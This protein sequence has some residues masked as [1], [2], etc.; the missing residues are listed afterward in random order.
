MIVA[1]RY[2]CR[3]WLRA[4]IVITGVVLS[5]ELGRRT[6]PALLGLELDHSLIGFLL[7]LE[8]GGALFADKV[9]R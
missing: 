9:R 8:L 6:D 2:S 5:C 3:L 4:L 7:E 1:L